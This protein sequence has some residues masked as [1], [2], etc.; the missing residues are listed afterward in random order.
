MHAL[1]TASP[2]VTPGSALSGRDAIALARLAEELSEILGE[3]ASDAIGSV[4]SAARPL[5]RTRLVSAW[6]TS[7]REAQRLALARGFAHPFEAVGLRTAMEHLA[8]DASSRVR[9]AIDCAIARRRAIDAIELPDPLAS[10][11][12]ALPVPA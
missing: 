8:Q 5:D 3:G 6:A 9:L 7:P 11:P 2:P 1:T 10:D 4:L 12:H